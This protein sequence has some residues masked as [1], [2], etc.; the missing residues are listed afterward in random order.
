MG[1]AWAFERN[2]A[3]AFR[4]ASSS[5]RSLDE[6][7][8]VHAT[9][10]QYFYGFEHTTAVK[11]FMV[12]FAGLAFVAALLL[13]MSLKNW[14][15]AGILFAAALTAPLN[16][17]QTAYVQTWLL[18]VQKLRAEIHL[19]LGIVLTLLVLFS[20]R[21][22][23]SR[24]PIQGLFMLALALYAALMMFIHATPS[25]ALQS[26]GFALATIPCFL[27]ASPALTRDFEGCLRMLR[28]IMWV[29]VIWTV[30]CSVQFVINPRY[31]LNINGRFWG[32]LA[33]AQ[34]AAI[35][36]A[37]FAMVA[38]W[39]FLNDVQKRT[40]PLWVA[41][42]AINLLFLLWTGSRTG[43]LMFLVGAMFVLYTRLGK[44]VIFLPVGGL[45]AIGLYTLAEE[46][47]IMSNVER[48]VS[49]DNT[50]GDVWQAQIRSFM[51]S[52]FIGVGWG[53]TGGSESSYL[54]GAAGYGIG[55]FGIIVLFLLWSVWM[56]FRFTVSR[57]L[58]PK[59]ERPL[60][61]LFIAWN[62]CYF[63]AAAFEGF[64]LGRSSTPQVMMLMFAGI[65]VYLKEQMAAARAAGRTVHDEDADAW[66]AGGDDGI[67]DENASEAYGFETEASG[68]D[69]GGRGT[70]G[71]GLPA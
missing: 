60:V 31:L 30:C 51:E 22:N 8:M 26:V 50:R 58:L 33:N 57:R 20:G 7:Q 55:F 12:G 44:A 4:A 43:A 6:A 47:Q 66:A 11:I 62:A 24:V 37:P 18:P 1:L 56:C 19:G 61:D 17:E 65:G 34:Q 35:L 59:H 49:T 3:P 69:A 21:I 39:L 67:V 14:V 48:L 9:L 40:K 23:A 71:G 15:I 29:S 68:R 46:L 63:A 27:V 10:A 70:V 53:E 45:V 25:E 36:V 54:G 64:M 5:A 52:P 42:L 16:V 41:L 2:P 38:L 13:R 32:M 28:T